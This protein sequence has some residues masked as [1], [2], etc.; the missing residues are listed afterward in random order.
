MKGS[1]LSNF[2]LPLESVN[3]SLSSQ[4]P[5]LF[6]SIKGSERS[7]KPSGLGRADIES[8]PEIGPLIFSLKS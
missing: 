3:N 1:S 2:L 4:V 6:E 7:T 5:F 8:V